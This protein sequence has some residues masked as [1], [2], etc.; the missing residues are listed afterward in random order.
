MSSSDLT[1]Q[2]ILAVFREL[3]SQKPIEKI[4]VREI[5]DRC[6]INRNTF[7]YH[8]ADKYQ[9][10]ERVFETEVLPRLAPFLNGD[11]WPDSIVALCG[12]MRES[13]AFYENAMKSAGPGSLSWLLVNHYKAFLM[14]AS[15][16]RFRSLEVSLEDQEMAARFYSH[17]IIGIIGDWVDNGMKKDPASACRMIRAVVTEHLFS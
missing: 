17:A 3:L 6:G 13:P 14:E 12:L 9:I 8:F 4:S 7:Y 2:A 1:T 10:L 15:A 11:Q 5:S 16:P